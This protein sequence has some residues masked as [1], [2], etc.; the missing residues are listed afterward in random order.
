VVVVNSV[1]S[2]LAF[3]LRYSPVFFDQNSWMSLLLYTSLSLCL[4]L[5]GHSWYLLWISRDVLVIILLINIAT[6]GDEPPALSMAMSAFCISLMTK[7]T[8]TGP[9]EALAI[10]AADI[11]IL[12]SSAAASLIVSSRVDQGESIS[13]RS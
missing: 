1:H 4:L 9:T 5:S 13:C 7:D 3:I 2:L 6:L 10:A 11:C 12:S 8:T